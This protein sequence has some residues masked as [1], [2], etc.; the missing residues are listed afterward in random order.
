MQ[1]LYLGQES[2]STQ[3][4][5]L[6]KLGILAARKGRCV[7]VCVRVFSHLCAGTLSPRTAATMCAMENLRPMSTGHSWAPLLIR[8]I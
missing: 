5:D 7:R 2:R 4:K 1:Q 8:G 3:F 6:A